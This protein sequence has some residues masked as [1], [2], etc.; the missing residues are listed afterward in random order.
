MFFWLKPSTIIVIMKNCTSEAYTYSPF[1]AN[2]K[3]VLPNPL[4]C[5][6]LCL[7]VQKINYGLFIM[8]S[9]NLENVK[10][11]SASV[12]MFVIH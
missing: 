3:N 4:I 11:C 1:S 10:C 9:T 12:G 2:L 6:Y 7:T 5:V 8:F